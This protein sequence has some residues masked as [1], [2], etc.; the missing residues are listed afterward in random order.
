MAK[1]NW[2]SRPIML[3]GPSCSPP[4]DL[5]RPSDWIR[6]PPITNRI[7]PRIKASDPPPPNPTLPTLAALGAPDRPAPPS[8]SALHAVPLAGPS[9]FLRPRPAP[10]IPSVATPSSTRLRRPRL[11]SRRGGSLLVP[12]AEAEA[13]DPAAVRRLPPYSCGGPSSRRSCRDEAAADRAVQ[14]TCGG[15]GVAGVGNGGL[16]ASGGVVVPWRRRTP[17]CLACFLFFSFF[18]P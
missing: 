18:V 1:T 7:Q 11:R 5:Y 15:G 17:A 10:P 9:L 3:A 4:A 12:A 6:R 13:G 8:S 16:A 2:A 14:P